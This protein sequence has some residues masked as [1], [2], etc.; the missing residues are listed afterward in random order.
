VLS[1]RSAPAERSAAPG[2]AARAAPQPTTARSESPPAPT[3]AAV[4]GAGGSPAAP[5]AGQVAL[6]GAMV[7]VRWLDGDTF[8]WRTAGRAEEV[9]A[10]LAGVN[11]L[12]SYGPVHQWGTWRPAELAQ[13]ADEAGKLAASQG[14]RCQDTGESGGYGR[15][16]VRCPELAAQLLER[17][18]AHLFILAG[19]ADGALLERQHRAQEQRRGMWAKGVPKQIVTSVHSTA[20]RGLAG[21]AYNRVVD[22]RTG[23]AGKAHHRRRYETCEWA[24]VGGSCMVYIPYQRRYGRRRPTCSPPP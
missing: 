21:K 1:C 18:L 14:W 11:T 12:E 9:R 19:S 5:V 10:R 8:A 22:A 23:R 15:K 16:L 3:A 24:C 17:G 20:E 6:D 7:T 2:R 13:L 4:R